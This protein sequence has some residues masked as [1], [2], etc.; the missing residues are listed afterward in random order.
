M[1]S[2][3]RQS[4][5]PGVEGS[6]TT[7]EA[8]STVRDR[9]RDQGPSDPGLRRVAL[10][11]P[12]RQPALAAGTDDQPRRRRRAD[13]L[14]ATPTR[15]L[16]HRAPGRLPGQ[17]EDRDLR[18]RLDRR[19]PA[20]SLGLD[21]HRRTEARQTSTGCSSSPTA[22]GSTRSWSASS[23]PTR[24]PARSRSTSRTC[25]RCRSTTSSST[26]SPPTAACW[27][28]RP[29]AR[30]TNAE[31]D[32]FPWNDRRSPTRTRAQRLGLDSGPDGQLCPGAVRPFNPRLVAGT[33]NPSAG[34]LQRL[35]PRSSTATTA[36]SSSATSTS[37]CRPGSP[38]TCAGSPTAPRP[39]SPRPPRSSGRVEQAQPEL[40]RPRARSAPPTS[41]PAPAATPS[42]RSGRCTSSGP[43]KGAPLSL[44]AITPALA[45]PYD[46]GVVVVR[47]AL[48][49]DPQTAQ[50]TAVSDTVP[51]DHRRRPD[52]DALDPGQH[53]QAELHD[54]PDQLL[55]VL[56]RLAGDRR[57]GHASPTSPPTSTP[58]TARTAA[59]Q[60]EDD[61]APV[62]RAAQARTDEPG[63]AVR[64]ARPAPATP[65]SN[66]SR[67][68]CRRPSRSTS[69]TSAT[70]ARRKNWPRPSAPAGPRSAQASTDTPLLDQ[71]LSGPVYA[72]SGSGGLP[73]LAFI[74][75][76]QVNLVPRAETKT[77]A[78]AA[79]ADDRPGRPRRADRPLPA[80]RL[81]RQAR[82]PGQ[83]PQPLRQGRGVVHRGVRSSERQEMDPKDAPQSCLPDES[84][85]PLLDALAVDLGSAK[86]VRQ[87]LD[88]KRTK[89]L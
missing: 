3:D 4:F 50:V 58:S 48:H 65:T 53:R 32:F 57:P 7:N 66:R 21:L 36:T 22:S 51:R 80:D 47:V 68:P 11:D 44:V 38:A 9:H 8:D 86:S 27:R 34:A 78:K 74:L 40:S 15:E 29:T 19:S 79:A 49:V 28:P 43:F 25:R 39:R 55:A 6:L 62:G 26:S 76:G 5:N 14:H 45:G 75:D 16:R 82:L 42:T 83:H 85:T 24:R 31:A 54:Q 10:L 67:S 84:E 52:P 20:T 60:A 81:R 88:L 33:S 17:L 61:G 18:D 46:Y 1:T 23:S 41:P 37:R 2:C 56:G 30:S 73:R 12:R 64:P 63:A 89:V 69:A 70:S 35:P 72:V 77:S 13:R 71:P 59:L 87:V